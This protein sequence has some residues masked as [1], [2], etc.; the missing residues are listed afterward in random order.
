MSVPSASLAEYIACMDDDELI[1]LLVCGVEQ[2][3]RYRYAFAVTLRNITVAF[4]RTVS[5]CIS[6]LYSV[7]SSFVF[8]VCSFVRKQLRYLMVASRVLE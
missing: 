7:F 4:S 3:V 5:Q 8:R 1:T 2:Y 6:R